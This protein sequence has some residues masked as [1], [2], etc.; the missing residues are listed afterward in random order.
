[1]IN[2]VHQ[3][4]WSCDSFELGENW[5]N[6]CDWEF[7]AIWRKYNSAGVADPAGNPGNALSVF[8]PEVGWQ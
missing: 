3:D 6:A 1:M 8:Y 7:R 2:T 4:V 5:E